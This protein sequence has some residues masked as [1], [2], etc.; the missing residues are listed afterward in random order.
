MKIIE[1]SNQIA[2]IIWIT[3]KKICKKGKKTYITD[4]MLY[5]LKVRESEVK[6]QLSQIKMRNQ[7]KEM[8]E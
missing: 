7:L 4:A 5:L 6:I 1:I 2:L 8:L 3:F